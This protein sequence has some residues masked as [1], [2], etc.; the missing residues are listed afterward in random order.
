MASLLLRVSL[1][2]LMFLLFLLLPTR[3]LP[4][5]YSSY[6]FLLLLLAWRPYCMLLASLMLLLSLMLMHGVYVVGLP[7]CCCQL[8]HFY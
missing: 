1:L 4:M 2:L 8:S 6:E 5:F 3:L 7:A